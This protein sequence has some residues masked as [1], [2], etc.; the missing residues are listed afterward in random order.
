MS[1]DVAEALS[2][3][4]RKGILS[5]PTI[6]E[7]FWPTKHLTALPVLPLRQGHIA[8]MTAAGFLDNQIL[9]GQDGTDPLIIKGRTYKETL[10]TASAKT[11]RTESEVMRTT[12]RSLNLRTGE[13]QD[14]KP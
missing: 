8:L 9:P 10:T 12:I 11:S 6:R 13:R 1:I 2:E 3:A 7:R 5:S 14:I 4:A